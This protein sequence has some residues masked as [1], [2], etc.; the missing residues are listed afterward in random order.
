MYSHQGSNRSMLPAAEAPLGGL[1]DFG[2]I[3]LLLLALLLLLHQL[4]RPQHQQRADL[5]Q[6][7]HAAPLQPLWYGYP[8]L[9]EQGV[10]AS[11]IW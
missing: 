5:V 7:V 8:V 4:H 10:I 11:L 9:G 3:L 2:G 6:G 1:L